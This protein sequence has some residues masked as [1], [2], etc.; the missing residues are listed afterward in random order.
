MISDS[1]SYRKN[2]RAARAIEQHLGLDAPTPRAPEDRHPHASGIRA[3]R[4]RRRFERLTASLTPPSQ[5]PQ[6]GPLKVIDPHLIF[7]TID[8]SKDLDDLKKRLLASH[9][10]ECQFT[11]APGAAEPTGWSLR[12]AGGAGSWLKGSDVARGLS[13]KKVQERL[14]QRQAADDHYD[15][16]R[17]STRQRLRRSGGSFMAVLTGL[18]IEL[19]IRLVAGLINLIGRA[20]ARR[21]EVPAE[22]LGR[23]DVAEDGTPVLIEP[24]G[25]PA[26]APAD[27]QSRL[28]AARTVMSKAMDQAAEAIQQDDTGKLPTLSSAPEVVTERARVIR[29]LS[30]IEGGAGSGAEGGDDEFEYERERPQ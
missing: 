16:D 12:Q 23:I 30:E 19:G 20:L 24:V 18:S 28:D 25:L 11:N 17:E 8:E 26:D 3:E 4:G 6:K 15:R 7:S 9:N 14:A 10:I 29:L 27:Q 21:A 1:N 2:E 13:L 22:T 5:Q